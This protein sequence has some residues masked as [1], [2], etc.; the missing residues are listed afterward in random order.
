MA[1]YLFAWELGAGLGHLINIRPLA[2]GLAARGHNVVVALRD[3]SRARALFRGKNIALLQAP[4]KHRRTREFA[5]TLSFAHLL[6]NVGFGDPMELRGMVEAWRN[7]FTH[8][9]PDVIV[10]D[11]SP[12]ALLAARGV[13]AQR[14]LLGSGFFCPLDDS[15]LACLR[16]WLRPDLK[17]LEQDE[18]NLLATINQVLGDIGEPR[19][20]R[21]SQLYH[22]ADEHLLA[23][24]PELDHYPTRRGA[25]YWGIWPVDLGH[26]PVWPEGNGQ[27]IFAYL[28][29]FPGLPSLLDQLR[30]LGSPTI[31]VCDGVEAVIQQQFQAANIRFENEPLDLQQASRQCDLAVLNA[32]HGTAVAVLLAGKPSLLIPLYLEQALLAKAIMRLGAGL[33]ASSGE[34]QQISERLSLV[35]TDRRYAA[36]AQ[37]FAS[38]Y[39]DLDPQ[40]QV[41]AALDR[42]ERLPRSPAAI[43]NASSLH[44]LSADQIASWTREAQQFESQRQLDQAAAAYRQILAVNPEDF[45][46]HYRLGLVL[47][48]DKQFEEAVISFQSALAIRP[49]VP[50]VQNDLGCALWTLGRHEEAARLFQ[51]VLATEP[52][53]SNVHNNLG[54]VMRA[55]GRHSDAIASY[56]RALAINENVADFH[57]N[58]GC[59]LRADG[60]HEEALARYRRALELRPDFG[61]ALSNLGTLLLEQDR[62]VEAIDNHRKAVR[63]QPTNYKVHHNLGAAFLRAGR[64]DDAI[65][66]YDEALRMQPGVAEM[67]FNR[68][69]ACLTV[70]KYEEGWRGFESRLKSENFNRSVFQQPL[71]D[72]QALAE[73]TLLLHAEQGLGDTIQFIRYLT[74]VRALVPRT[75]V[76]VQSALVP[77]LKESHAGAIFGHDALV[78]KFDFQAPLL[79][80]PKILQTTLATIPAAN[81]YLKPNRQLMESWRDRLDELPGLKIGIHWQGSPKYDGDRWRSIPLRC[82]EP[83]SRIAGVQLV[84][85]QKNDGMEQLGSERFE[86]I[87]FGE[88]LDEVTGPFMDSAA[89]IQNL[90]LVITSDSAV[91]HLAGALGA[92]VWLC[93]AKVA[94][95]RWLLDR[96]DSPWY[97]TMRL[98]R[99]IDHGNWNELFERVA[100]QLQQEVH[101]V[102]VPTHARAAL[103][104]DGP[105]QAENAYRL[106]LKQHAKG[107][108]QEA[109]ES[110]RAALRLDSRHPQ[111]HNDLGC[112][113]AYLD[114]HSQALEHFRQAVAA[115]PEFADAHNNLGC[116]LRT[117]GRFEAALASFRTA[118]SLRPDF[119]DAINNMGNALQD[120]GRLDEAI[121]AHSQSLALKPRN[122]EAHN[123]LGGALQRK[124]LN[125]EALAHFDKTLSIKPNHIEAR[126]SRALIWL[127]QGDFPR[128]WPDYEA[129]LFSKRYK[130]RALDK[131]Q[132]DGSCIK[133]KTLLVHAEQGLGDTLQFIRFV[134]GAQ[135]CSKSVVIEVQPRLV[136]LLKQS[137]FV[138]IVA[139]GAELPEFDLHVPLLSLPGILATT[140]TSIPSKAAYLS[141]EPRLVEFWRQRLSSHSGMKV[142]INW[143]GSVT[144]KEDQVRSIPLEYFEPLARVTN[145][146]LISLQKNQGAEQLSTIGFP[147]VDL[148]PERDE[149]AAFV[150]TAAILKNLDLVVTSD[151]AIAHLAG[152]LGVP[153]WLCLSYVADWRWLIDLDNS[154]WYPS[155]RIFRQSQAANWASVF[156]SMA[157]AVGT[158]LL[159][160]KNDLA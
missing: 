138:D 130:T 37:R 127:L 76:A 155:M 67:E 59:A 63:I 100:A 38:K 119:A 25:K 94:D 98:F 84:S 55:L 78:P 159:R 143:Q 106:G 21:V 101:R 132:W 8:V 54:C 72:G 4:F 75:V 42:L 153:V 53:R 107:Q 62:F 109:V 48:Q 15:P 129:R 19:L 23:T 83:L 140:V 151:T 148:G 45:A 157:K 16:P 9:G 66:S 56:E 144:Y 90:D 80:I 135:R 64:F 6:C 87:Q 120:Q 117:H 46:A 113:L 26:P 43:R 5:P 36:A 158:D 126:Y 99:Q 123:S 51:D 17:Q 34:P 47:Q 52:S 88:D 74:H 136:P 145:V 154:P 77:L 133:D 152:A 31:V 112:A 14:V 10:F 104:V 41:S 69:I 96:D 131:P 150:D 50:D 141:A 142:G 27:K 110:Y 115:K 71:W 73:K 116:A 86:V 95:W 102:S 92:R 49:C 134:E 149:S 13:A 122:A 60:R 105:H 81:P 156:Q 118:I 3:L 33:G 20:T 30:K 61:D 57:N 44:R 18:E 58:L 160:R 103:R 137:G 121:A 108:I 35:R 28:K 93:L 24:F 91:A 29:P 70:G 12:T 82:F 125:A 1:T 89:I 68:G 40:R 22:P 79:S 2:E 32:N 124:G 85:L 65:A 128:G 97:P 7:L 111:A 114:N 11:H 139:R 147:V 146:T 39:A